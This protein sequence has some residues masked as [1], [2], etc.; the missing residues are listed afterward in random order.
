MNA[1]DVSGVHVSSQETWLSTR[2]SDPN[3]ALW[4]SITPPAN[5]TLTTMVR[6]R[7]AAFSLDLLAQRLHLRFPDTFSSRPIARFS[8]LGAAMAFGASVGLIGYLSLQPSD[9]DSASRHEQAFFVENAAMPGGDAATLARRGTP[10][11][12]H[13]VRLGETVG[14]VPPTR[15]AAAQPVMAQ[16]TAS[17]TARSIS[18]ET[19][20][21][22]ALAPQAT[23]KAKRT[24][25]VK[26][27]AKTSV[28]RATKFQRARISR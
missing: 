22:V 23:E 28:R 13:S 25:S 5:P 12:A 3:A 2:L 7:A 15:V 19:S 18:A 17:L 21:D 14:E 9:A 1:G 24:A 20:A 26:K 6:R 16:V 8:I 27:R 11:S 4:A 10:P